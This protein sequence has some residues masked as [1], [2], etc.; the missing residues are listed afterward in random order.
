MQLPGKLYRRADG[1]S[2]DSWQHADMGNGAYYM[3]GKVKTNAG[4]LGQR[5]ETVLKKV[6]S[7]LYENVP[8]KILKKTAVTRNGYKGFDITART[9]RGDIQRYNILVTP[10][11]VWVFKMS[12][13]NNYVE[14]PEAEQFFGSIRIRPTAASA[15]IDFTP[16]RGGFM[17]RMPRI[18]VQ[19]KDLAD[20]EGITRWDYEAT[21]S[22]TGDGF[23]LWKTTIQNYRFMEEDTADLALMEESFRG[24][25]WI[26]KCLSRHTGT[27]EGHACLD[28][29]YQQKD[30][31]FI[32][33]R[34][35]LHGPDYYV[36][37]AHSRGKDKPFSSWFNSLAFV[38]YRYPSFRNYTDLR[39]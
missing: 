27:F 10:G 33:A 34:F 29:C 16:S 6:D 8:G 15:W 36:L 26:D 17:I 4:F 39:A 20:P 21:D 30:G 11:E 32:R 22:A 18:P 25:D 19:A 31:S 24:S 12:G 9:R 28:A 35:I 2:S 7:L 13:T 38:P 3:I 5:E 23:L 37:A 1:R 14:G